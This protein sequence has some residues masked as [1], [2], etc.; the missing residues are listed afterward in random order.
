MCIR[1]R[2]THYIDVTDES[3]VEEAAQFVRKTT[4]RLDILVNNAA[5][6]RGTTHLQDTPLEE[7]NQ[8]IWTCS[9]WVFEITR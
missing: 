3:S 6:G 8:Y 4:G 2:Y 5:L 1:D 7:W 9:L